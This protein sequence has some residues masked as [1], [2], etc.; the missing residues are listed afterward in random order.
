[1]DFEWL[2][3]INAGSSLVK[4]NIYTYIILMR[5]I[6]NKEGYAYVVAVATWENLNI[7]LSILL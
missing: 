6:D 5:N 4:K 7:F 2:W 3:Y 1:M